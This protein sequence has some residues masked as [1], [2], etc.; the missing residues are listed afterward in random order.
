MCS[1]APRTK[2]SWRQE[3]SVRRPLKEKPFFPTRRD[4]APGGDVLGLFLRE[5]DSSCS[6]GDEAIEDFCKKHPVFSGE[7]QRTLGMITQHAWIDLYS[8]YGAYEK[9]YR[10]W[11][12]V[13]DLQSVIEEVRSHIM[14]YMGAC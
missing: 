13:A 9:A 2:K 8:L 12:T 5:N 4:I 1:K 7:I 14:V 11:H 3:F 6:F 10:G